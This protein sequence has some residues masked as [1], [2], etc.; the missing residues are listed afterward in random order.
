MSAR[1]GWSRRLAAFALAIPL[2]CFSAPDSDA[3]ERDHVLEWLAPPEQVDGYRV[4]LGPEARDYDEVIDLGP[5]DPDGDGI[6]R[7]SLV[8]DA[9][10]PY[11]IA[12]TA[13]NA[14]G[15]SDYSNEL[16]LA[17]AVC[18]PSSCDDGDPCTLDDCVDFTCV[19]TTLPDF[20]TC[21]SGSGICLAGVCEV[22]DCVSDAD[23]G[24]SDACD[25]VERC[26]D[27]ACVPGPAPV[28][29][30]AS[31]CLQSGCAAD[32]GCWTDPLPDGTA[33][34]D[35][36]AD[37]V[38]DQC[39]S[40]TCTGTAWVPE[41]VADADCSDSDACNGQE[42][43]GSDGLCYAGSAPVCEFSGVC[44]DP[45]CDP[46]EGCGVVPH[47]DGTPCDDGSAAT[48]DDRC[49]AGT[50]TGSAPPPECVAHAD[51]SDGNACNGTEQ[52]TALGECTAGPPPVCEVSGQCAD[53]ICDPLMG[54]VVTPKPDGTGCD[55]GSAATV[56]DRCMAGVC[57]GSEPPASPAP[58]FTVI[59][60]TP[61]TI[62]TRRKWIEIHGSGFGKGMDVRFENGGEPPPRIMK[63][64]LVDEGRLRV[65]IRVRQWR[66]R[67]ER[68]FDVVVTHP[69]D[70]EIRIPD[71]LTVVH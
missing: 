48:V 33:C 5:I 36:L 2:V 70:G 65:R 60:V 57:E 13:Y 7:V 30:M 52:C 26:V 10:S 32:T 50:C 39:L 59:E 20:S 9:G 8:L 37:T 24:N 18:D 23:C 25:G 11:F 63:T 58:G 34:D 49:L 22:P 41:C 55:D 4:F 53:G 14:G 47:V 3:A 27:Y 45:V 35:G 1:T 16:F 29:S 42:Q 21:G 15:E 54:C 28:C 51:C 46:I 43:C 38:D 31:P 67:G 66:V 19:N 17:A 62:E 71:A 12:M 40:G 64:E 61:D 69:V 44:G 68:S 6:S 56:D